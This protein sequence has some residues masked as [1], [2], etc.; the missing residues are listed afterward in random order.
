MYELSN[1]HTTSIPSPQIPHE[2]SSMGTGFANDMP[3]ASRAGTEEIPTAPPVTPAAPA[4]EYTAT[5]KA[6]VAMVR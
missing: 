5:A 3:K 2:R 6:K 4:Y 1:S